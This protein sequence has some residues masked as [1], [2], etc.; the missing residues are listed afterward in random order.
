[1]GILVWLV[2]IVA[3]LAVWKAA[4]LLFWN[5]RRMTGLTSLPV[6]MGVTLVI[7]IVTVA[8]LHAVRGAWAEIL[9]TALMVGVASGE[10]EYNRGMHSP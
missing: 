10:Y 5:A 8:F 7:A 3:F 1:M 9:L 6:T 4:H 2:Q